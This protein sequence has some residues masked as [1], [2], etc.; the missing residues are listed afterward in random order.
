LNKTP[1]EAEA[2]DPFDL[3]QSPGEVCGFIHRKFGP[4]GL[5]QLLTTRDDDGT[6]ISR[7]IVMDAA[8]ELRLGPQG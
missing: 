7:E 5:R 3:L 1:L 8:A 2:A 4:E 6:P